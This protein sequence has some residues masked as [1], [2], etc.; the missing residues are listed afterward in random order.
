MRNRRRSGTAVKAAVGMFLRQAR[1]PD[2]P[3]K[4][5]KDGYLEV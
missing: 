1:P 5:L 2:H 3:Q 4:E